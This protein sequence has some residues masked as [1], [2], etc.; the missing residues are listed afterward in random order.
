MKVLFLT[1]Y[2][3]EG[4]SS[5]YRVYQYLPHLERMGVICEA[6]SFMDAEFYRLSFSPGKTIQKIYY[7]FI[8]SARRIRTLMRH[9]EYDLIYMQRELF[10]FGPPLVERWLKRRGAR[11]VFDYDDALFIKKPSRHNPISTLLRSSE[12][13]WKIFAISDCVVAGNDWLRD[14]A[15]QKCAR[16]VTIDVAEDA[17]RIPEKRLRDSDDPVLI[18]W[19]GSQS[20]VKYIRLVEDV[21][22]QIHAKFSNTRF[23]IVGGGEFDLPGLPLT[24]TDWSL[25]AEVEALTRFDI[26]LMPLPLE[27]WSRGKSGGKA[28]TYM[29]SGIAVVCTRIGYNNV[30]IDD[31]KTGFLCQTP[32]EWMEA[33]SK[34]ICDPALRKRVGDAARAHVAE[35]FSPEGQARKLA[36]LFAELVTMR[37]KSR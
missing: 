15:A 24:H 3:I 7:T 20:T 35:R 8:S 17:K 27:E 5:R 23:E 1:R 34:L 10:P 19:L 31:G 12:K 2:P 32:E 25:Q 37:G 29:A 4:A 28:R 13:V 26:G 14:M 16:A 21:L 30:L 36:D 9:R 11:L 6:E 33:L 18:G 22:R